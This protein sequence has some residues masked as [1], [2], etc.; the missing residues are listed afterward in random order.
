MST[1]RSKI[2]EA[3]G[4]D[5][6]A[7]AGSPSTQM[8]LA[9]AAKSGRDG[10]HTYE[11]T[12]PRTVVDVHRRRNKVAPRDAGPHGITLRMRHARRTLPAQPRETRERDRS[13]T[14]KDRIRARRSCFEAEW[15]TCPNCGQQ[16]GIAGVSTGSEADLDAD[17]YF[18]DEVMRHE[19]GEC[20][21]CVLDARDAS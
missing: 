6:I 1:L 19:S 10:G 4:P 20:T 5:D 2:S 17:Q 18:D 12:V 15:Y 21:E 9:L 14:R 3:V 8:A 16:M 11:G 7:R 13:L